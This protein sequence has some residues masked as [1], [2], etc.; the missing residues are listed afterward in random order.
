M[1]PYYGVPFARAKEGVYKESFNLTL[2]GL[3]KRCAKTNPIPES[4]FLAKLEKEK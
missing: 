2:M 1:V 3:V 4:R